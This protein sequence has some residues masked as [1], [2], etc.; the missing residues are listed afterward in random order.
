[1]QKTEHKLPIM[2]TTS[3]FSTMTPTNAQIWQYS[4]QKHIITNLRCNLEEDEQVIHLVMI[5]TIQVDRNDRNKSS[6]KYS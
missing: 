2:E 4:Q 6:V 3:L 5:E 1:M